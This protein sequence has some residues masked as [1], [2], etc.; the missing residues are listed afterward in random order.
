MSAVAIVDTSVLLNVLDVPQRNQDRDAVLKELESLID[1]GTNILLPMA[2]IIE[3]GNHI[4]RIA[5]GDARRQCAKR[6]ADQ[7]RMALAGDAPWQPMQ[8]PTRGDVGIWIDEFPDFATRKLSIA[9]LS[10]V[11]EWEAVCKRIKRIRIYIWSLDKHLSAYN[12]E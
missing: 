2:S 3:T 5:N 11:K 7:V 1:E 8:T 6:F 10:I 12:R 4:S 9:D